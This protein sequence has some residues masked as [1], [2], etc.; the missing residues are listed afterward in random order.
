MRR[1]DRLAV[2]VFTVAAFAAMP[3]VSGLSAQAPQTGIIE[4]LTT[5]T[6]AQA[7]ACGR[8]GMDCAV[9]P[10]ELCPADGRYAA[11]IATPF[12]RVALAV[13]DAVKAGRRPNPMTP[14]AATRWGVGIFVFPAENSAKA[15]AIQRLEI[16]R[17]GRAI[18]PTTSTIGPIT[19]KNADGTSRQLARGFFAFDADAFAATADVTVVFVGASGEATCMLD[20]TRLSALR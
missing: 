2:S 11:R 20:R 1:H 4:R 14:G 18:Q 9:T 15:D 10:Y 8:R 6:H 16:R 12:S 5:E 7:V 17:E 19:V 3:G 13:F